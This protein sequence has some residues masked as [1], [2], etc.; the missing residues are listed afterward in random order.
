[1][2]FYLV[3]NNTVDDKEIWVERE[4]EF[5]DMLDIMQKECEET[6]MEP[7]GLMSTETLVARAAKIAWELIHPGMEKG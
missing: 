5:L 4:G 2:K 3:Y 6:G 7:I 1:M